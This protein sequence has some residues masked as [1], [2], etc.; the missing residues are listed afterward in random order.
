MLMCGGLGTRLRPWSY[1][2]PKPM[3]PI[4]ETPIL[5]LLLERLRLN[6]ITEITLSLG[7]K[8]ELIESYFRDGS[9]LGVTLHY[10]REQEPLGT[11]G[12]LNLLRDRLTAPFLMMNGDLVTRLDFRK[13]AAFHEQ[14]QAEITVGTKNYQHQVPYGVIEDSVDRVTQL[15]EKPTYS[16][17]INA[18]IYLIN[19][20]ALDLLPSQGRF[21]A[22]QLIQAAMDANRPVYSYLI[23]EYWLDI[24]R[25]EDYEQAN[26]D[27]QRW[28]DER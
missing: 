16:T 27:A 2:I 6:D 11:A 7:Y 15:R 13:F 17:R 12:A 4:G 19:P 26:L 25:L 9:H 22:T 18:G 21:D 28:L 23:E 5:E 8:A 14:H 1:V 10:V 3:F 20:P 24:G